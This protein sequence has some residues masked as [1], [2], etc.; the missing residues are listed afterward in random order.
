MF[1]R[2][3]LIGIGLVGSSLAQV[4]RQENLAGHISISTR[5]QETLQRAEELALGDSYHMDAAEA[6]A[7]CDLVILCT[8]VGAIGSV[9][10]AIASSLKPGAILTDVGSV[11]QSVIAQARPHVPDNVH[12]I[13][14][15]PIAGTEESG[16]DA[17]FPSLFKG[18]WTILTPETGCLL[19]TSPSPRDA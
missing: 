10:E 19:Y 3:A 15:H 13:A 6:V 14:G 5:R 16:P 9:T 8:P 11:K 7:D 12:F 2:V 1:D 18:R 17:G 4:M